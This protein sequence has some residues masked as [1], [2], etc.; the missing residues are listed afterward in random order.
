MKTFLP[1]VLIFVLSFTRCISLQHIN[2]FSESSLSGIKQFKELGYGFE[3]DCLEKCQFKVAQA[4]EIND[5]LDCNCVKFAQADSVN[6]VICHVLVAY[7]SGLSKLS[8][9]HSTSYNVSALSEQVKSMKWLD[10][11]HANACTDIANVLLQATTNGYRRK[12]LKNYIEKADTSIHVLIKKLQS[13]LKTELFR[14]LKTKSTR[15]TL[16]YQDA[17][18]EKN[19]SDYQKLKIAEEYYKLF[20]EIEDKKN[21]ILTYANGL[22]A[23]AEGHR[24]LFEN[25]NKLNAREVKD[26]VVQS[27]LNISSI[28]ADFKTIRN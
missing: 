27:A 20:N 19:L 17:V 16:F 7:F 5:K 4:G 12:E 8:D 26:W 13:N 18:R 6:Q 28:Y 2:E 10:E 14:I 21:D 3:Q 9:S 15:L 11:E 25:R 24:K 22:D 23:I 1:L